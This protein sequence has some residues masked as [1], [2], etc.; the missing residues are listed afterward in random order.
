[1]RL[2]QAALWAMVPLALVNGWPVL[3]CICADGKYLSNCPAL[4]QPASQVGS[5]P[6]C[7][8][9][10]CRET[11]NSDSAAPACCR[12]A[13][14]PNESEPADQSHG[15]INHKGCC[16]VVVQSGELPTL[17]Q[18]VRRADQQAP[19]PAS[20]ILPGDRA[21]LLALQRRSLFENDTGLA[22]DLV[23]TLRRLII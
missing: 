1:L 3:G 7:C 17:L 20:A 5:E 18:S 14:D 11:A 4:R 13:D 16:H 12:N 22:F 19:V 2:R 15:I 23:I 8:T 10:A 9:K 6:C 21:G